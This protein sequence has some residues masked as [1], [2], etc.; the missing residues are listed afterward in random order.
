CCMMYRKC[1]PHIAFFKLM[2]A[3]TFIAPISQWHECEHTCEH[4]HATETLDTSYSTTLSSEIEDCLLCDL[5]FTSV[6]ENSRLVLPNL[7]FAFPY[8]EEITYQTPDFFIPQSLSLRAP[9][10]EF[11]PLI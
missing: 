11:K 10:G 5:E 9:P 7:T 1:I 4:D 8:L 3:I 6:I 2:L